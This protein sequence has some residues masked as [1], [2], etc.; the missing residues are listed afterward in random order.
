MVLKEEQW[1]PRG[2]ENKPDEGGSKP[3]CTKPSH[4]KSLAHVLGE[5]KPG[6]FQT[7]GFPTFFGKGPDCV[8]DAS[9]AVLL[10]PQRAQFQ[11]FF[12][13]RGVSFVRFSSPCPLRRPFGFI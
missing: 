11:A 7:G 6:G 10:E 4:S 9:E 5:G 1:H 8:A 13:L 12:C 2:V 3:E